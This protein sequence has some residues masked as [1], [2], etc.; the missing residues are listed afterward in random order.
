MWGKKWKKLTIIIVLSMG[1]SLLMRSSAH[2]SLLLLIIISWSVGFVRLKSDS[3]LFCSNFFCFVLFCFY[4][5]DDEIADSTILWYISHSNE[6]LTQFTG[7][8]GGSDT[9]E[10]L[11][12]SFHHYNC[13]LL[14]WFKREFVHTHTHTHTHRT[15]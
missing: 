11:S 4:P 2:P 13:Y 6:F 8:S 5:L 1:Q 7:G 3:V 9:K 14:W 15:N 10:E 12:A